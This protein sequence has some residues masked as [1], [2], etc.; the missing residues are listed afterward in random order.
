MVCIAVTRLTVDLA[1]A[2]QLIFS[3]AVIKLRGSVE[4]VAVHDARNPTT[5]LVLP[6][7]WR[8]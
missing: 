2:S 3:V 1:G 6:V 5:M 4:D 8:V 7:S